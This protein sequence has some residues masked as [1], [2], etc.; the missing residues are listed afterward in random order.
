MKSDPRGCECAEARVRKTWQILGGNP[1][2]K[3]VIAK[4]RLTLG[5]VS[6][7]DE[8]AKFKTAR[9]GFFLY[10]GSIHI[11][12][13]GGRTVTTQNTGGYHVK[14]SSHAFRSSSNGSST[15]HLRNIGIGGYL[16]V[17]PCGRVHRA[18]AKDIRRKELTSM[19]KEALDT[20]GED[21]M[22]KFEELTTEFEQLTGWLKEV[23]GGKLKSTSRG[24]L[25]LFVTGDGTVSLQSIW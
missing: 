7:A 19:T 3:A 18:I 24:R 4:H 20:G 12:V 11:I 17:V 25:Q 8:S 10:S 5:Y 1:L 21:E 22:E 9:R 6:R 16:H 23:L 13:T 14:T 15:R 2:S